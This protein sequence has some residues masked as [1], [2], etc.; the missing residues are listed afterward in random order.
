[1]VGFRQGG[2][3]HAI[4][5]AIQACPEEL[6]S[7]MWSSILL[8]GGSA[9]IPNLANR[10]TQELRPIAPM[11]SVVNVYQCA[12]PALANWRGA[13]IYASRPIFR[14]LVT[15]RDQYKEVGGGQQVI[16]DEHA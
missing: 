1:M 12:N 14:Q 15:T 13:A 6:R 9:N 11:D 2:I 10:I 3:V 16:A 7:S 5:Q 8:T 4:H